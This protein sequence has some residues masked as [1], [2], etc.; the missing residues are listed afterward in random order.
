MPK[1]NSGDL[2]D[3]AVIGGGL[4]GLSCA[5]RARFIKSHGSYPMK[6]VIFEASPKIGGLASLAKIKVTGP[7]FE[8]PGKQLVSKLAADVKRYDIPVINSRIV[9]IGHA[10]ALDH[11]VLTGAGGDVYKARTA[12]V[13][14][15]VRPLA[16]DGD[17]FGRGVKITFMGYDNVCKT[18]SDCIEKNDENEFLIYGNRFSGNLINFALSALLKKYGPGRKSYPPVFLINEQENKFF[19][20]NPALKHGEI[21]KFGRILKYHG[22]SALEALD[23]ANEG[24]TSRLELRSLLLD[25]TSFE[26]RPDFN[27]EMPGEKVLRT[28]D[29]FLKVDF[30]MNTALPGIF[31]AGDIT[32]PYFCAAR[33]ISSGIA[34]AFSAY[35][36]VMKQKGMPNPGL[37]AYEA[38]NRRFDASYREV[39]VLKPARE[40]IALS[41]NSKI[42][43]FIM[44][45]FAGIG[46]PELERLHK[47]IKR[48]NIIGRAG[49]NK[50]S[51]ILKIPLGEVMA[52]FTEMILEKLVTIA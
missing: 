4:S 33:A 44:A 38:S 12:A 37:F 5:V 49:Y 36:V 35:K 41:E 3:L 19:R 48:D 10:E 15:G 6:T 30:Q 8:I 29:G 20:D 50:I 23:V 18:I 42:A 16:N 40:T 25:Y 24:K 39:P 17:Y 45:R 21:F 1:T 31:A 14:S 27:I 13:C 28:K 32:G 22:G 7:G 43:R 34:A 51:R 11:L 2:I 52:L 9:K 26:L 46:R 47:V